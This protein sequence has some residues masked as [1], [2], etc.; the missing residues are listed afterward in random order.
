MTHIFHIMFETKERVIR[1]AYFLKR[2][3]IQ[4]KI[5]CRRVKAKVLAKYRDREKNRVLDI[6]HKVAYKIVKVH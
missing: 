1:T 4:S 3:K 2:R 6:Y 5:R